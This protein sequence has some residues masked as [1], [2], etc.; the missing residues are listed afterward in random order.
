MASATDGWCSQHAGGVSARDLVE[1]RESPVAGRPRW[2]RSRR[3]VDS[4]GRMGLPSAA[5][6]CWLAVRPAG[7]VPTG[8]PGRCIIGTRGEPTSPG[9]DRGRRGREPVSSSASAPAVT[10]AGASPR[11]GRLLPEPSCRA[12]APRSVLR[13]PGGG[14]PLATRARAGTQKRHCIAECDIA[15]GAGSRRPAAVSVADRGWRAC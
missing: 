7:A 13:L 11:V 3:S 14:V 8:S 5:G 9:T 10:V 1:Q 4:G 15:A 12:V 2:R 6:P